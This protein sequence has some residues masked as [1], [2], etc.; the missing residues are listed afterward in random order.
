MSQSN[1]KG[2]VNLVTIIIL[3]VGLIVSVYLVKQKTNLL[4]KA[5]ETNLEIDYSID[6]NE[7][8]N[9]SK[10]PEMN[11]KSSKVRYCDQYNRVYSYKHGFV[12]ECLPVLEACLE[13]S[14]PDE[15]I[16]AN[17]FLRGS[18]I[19]LGNKCKSSP[20]RD[21][22]G[23]YVRYFDGTESYG[24]AYDSAA[25]CPKDEPRCVETYDA[26]SERPYKAFCVR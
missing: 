19:E 26:E 4:P 17:C 13:F 5:S 23:R 22:Y 18:L 25:F 21:S 9:L 11:T 20:P 14:L 6:G 8:D 1:E 3:V 24:G 15:T 16:T 2:I 7:P 12:K 10:S